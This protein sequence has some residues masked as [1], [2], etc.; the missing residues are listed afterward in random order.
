MDWGELGV[1][2]DGLPVHLPMPCNAEGQGPVADHEAETWHCWCGDRDCLL[3]RALRDAW[4][5]GLRLSLV[6][7]PEC[8]V[9][10]EAESPRL[11]L[12]EVVARGRQ[13]SDTDPTWR[14][15][16]SG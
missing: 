14:G 4:R 3:D 15:D 16:Y 11:S 1:G 13:R 9:D 12:A 8:D 2:E 7:P 5:S 6:E 10:D